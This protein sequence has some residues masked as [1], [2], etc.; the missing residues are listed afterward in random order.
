MLD[1]L[2][3]ERLVIRSD[4]SQNPLGDEEEPAR[5]PVFLALRGVQTR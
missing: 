2:A 1:D 3:D 5:Q 4:F